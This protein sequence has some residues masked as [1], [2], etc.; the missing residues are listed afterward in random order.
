MF[1]TVL[2]L[3]FPSLGYGRTPRSPVKE[4]TEI[5]HVL[6]DFLQSSAYGVECVHVS[7]SLFWAQK[8]GE[9]VCQVAVRI[10]GRGGRDCLLQKLAGYLLS[11]HSYP[12]CCL[13]RTLASVFNSSRNLD[14]HQSLRATDVLTAN[15]CFL[16]LCLALFLRTN[17]LL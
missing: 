13:W 17:S 3:G 2:S 12:S 10:Y 8:W 5:A 4:R 9:T 11:E 15:R 1:K 7:G 6:T 14:V 16:V